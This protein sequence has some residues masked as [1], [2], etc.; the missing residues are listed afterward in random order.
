MQCHHAGNRNLL[1]VGGWVVAGDLLWLEGDDRELYILQK[2]TLHTPVA[3]IVAD[4]R[5]SGIGDGYSSSALAQR[6]GRSHACRIAA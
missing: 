5:L 1:L 3:G 6:Q 4:G 2:F